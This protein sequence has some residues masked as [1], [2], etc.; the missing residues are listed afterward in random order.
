MKPFFRALEGLII[1]ALK[2][3]AP[4]GAAVSLTASTLLGGGLEIDA[5]YPNLLFEEGNYLEVAWYGI[6][7]SVTGTINGDQPISNIN[8]FYDQ[9]NFGL[10]FDLSDQLVFSLSSFE[11]VGYDVQYPVVAPFITSPTAAS[12]KS[13]AYAVVAKYQATENFSF[14]GGMN[15]ITLSGSAANLPGLPNTGFQF[16]ND[17]DTGVI[18]G[19]AYS[20]PE[21]ALRVSFTYESGTSH[22]LSTSVGP[23]GGTLIS[24]IF[25]NTTGGT[26]E[27]YTFD[28]QT[29]IATDTLLYGRFRH[30]LHSNNDIFLGGTANL[31]DFSDEQTYVLGVGRKINETVSVAVTGTYEDGSGTTSDLNPSDGKVT[32]SG[33]PKF[34]LTENMELSVG[35]SYSWAG[36]N[37]T[38]TG[39][40]PFKENSAVAYGIK[41]GFRF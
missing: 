12:V 24:G 39:N 5:W 41:L 33:G 27:S 36:D 10:K 28:F 16:Y 34:E 13:R 38:T 17:G 26:P 19:A 20:K 14:Y 6:H 30:V 9:F 1:N 7:P 25:P 32:I 4:I 21:I 2:R 31:T 15:Y 11:P 3:I 29:G 35:A 40:I 23:V 8:P 18:V 22:S 37:V